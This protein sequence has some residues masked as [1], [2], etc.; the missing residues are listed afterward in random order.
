MMHRFD[1]LKY[2]WI[3]KINYSIYKP[4]PIL[5]DHIPKCAGNA[6]NQFLMRFYSPKVTFSLDGVHFENSVKE[7]KA[8]SKK[9]QLSFSL[10]HGHSANK[11]I[12]FTHPNSKILT[13]LRDPIDRVVSHYFYIKTYPGHF[14]HDK[15]INDNILLK[16]YCA[17]NLS[18]DLENEYTVHFSQLPLSEVRKNEEAALELAYKNILKQYDLIGFQSNLVDFFT[19]F[20]EMMQ[21]PKRNISDNRV[22]TTSKR[23]KVKELDEETLNGIKK[24]NRLDILLYEKLTAN[25]QNGVIRKSN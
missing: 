4:S 11:L 24:Y 13:I 25:K 3:R 9:E 16:D 22:N 21:L 6:V 19:A 5:F 12:D 7:F 14:L 1:V 10:I 23:P 20:S 15:I 18:N 2:Q 8:L 17:L